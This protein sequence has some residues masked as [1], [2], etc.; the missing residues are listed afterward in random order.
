MCILTEQYI[1]VHVECGC[2]VALI[3]ERVWTTTTCISYYVPVLYTQLY[4]LVYTF[5]AESHHEV[6]LY[7]YTCTVL[8]FKCEQLYDVLTL[9]CTYGKTYS[10]R[11]YNG[12]YRFLVNKAL[13]SMFLRDVVVCF[14]LLGRCCILS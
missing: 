13:L 9:M 14:F 6:W 7:A 10:H 12:D 4:L 5:R 8:E 3:T 2:N 1:D 11:K